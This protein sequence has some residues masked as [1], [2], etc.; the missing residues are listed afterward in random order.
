MNLQIF[1]GNKARQAGRQAGRNTQAGFCYEFLGAKLFFLSPLLLYS[2][3]NLTQI[4]E[5]RV[6]FFS[7]SYSVIL[8]QA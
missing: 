8:Y 5:Q 3:Y 4:L 6:Y 1:W 7:S 2:V